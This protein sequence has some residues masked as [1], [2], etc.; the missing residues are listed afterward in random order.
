M[1]TSLLR[2]RTWRIAAAIFLVATTCFYFFPTAPPQEPLAP[3]VAAYSA[4]GNGTLGFEKILVV[5]S[6]PSWRTRGLQAA[7]NFTGLDITTTEQPLILD[8]VIIAFQNLGSE[9][10]SRP[11]YG[12]AKAWL[13]HID[14]MKYV[15]ASGLESALVIEDDVDWDITIHKQ[16]ALFSEHLRFFTNS[17]NGDSSSY[18]A[19]WDIIWIG[20]CGEVLHPETPYWIYPDPTRITTELYA[21]WSKKWLQNI[22]E[23]YRAIQKSQQ[24]ICT[25]A[26]GVSHAGARKILE[27][28]GGGKDEAYD[29]AMSRACGEGRLRCYSVNPEIMH[30]YNPKDGTG[31][32]SPTQEADGKGH[33][34]SEEAFENSMGSTANVI[35]S[36]RCAALFNSTCLQP[37]TRAEDY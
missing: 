22:P 4:V 33:S 18:G 21:G 6:R 26:Y 36:A 10:G 1:K 25:F 15:V 16:M 14:I 30:H 8:E 12:S 13:A 29:V 17:S 2:S 35:N 3:P 19:A 37:P 27:V 32:V 28:L 31:Y 5:S 20:H 7:G 34:A 9:S 11:P 24:A 23:G